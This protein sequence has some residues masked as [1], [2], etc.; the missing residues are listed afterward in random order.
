MTRWFGCLCVFHP[1]FNPGWL[2]FHMSFA[3]CVVR[4]CLA[5][6]MTVVVLYAC[7]VRPSICCA[8][9]VNCDGPSGFVSASA[10]LAVPS[11]CAS[12]T[13]PFC[14]CCI[15]QCTFRVNCLI[16]LW[17]PLNAV[18]SVIVDALSLYSVVGSVC[19]YPKLFSMFLYHMIS[20]VASIVAVSS[21]SHDDSV[22][23]GCLWLR[24]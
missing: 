15:I 10:T 24:A 2:L 19:V 20:H 17:L 12:L 11:M 13:V 21:A 4:C 8:C 5:M 9:G 18:P 6:G 14:T 3:C 16:L 7:F 1:T 23:V 22:T